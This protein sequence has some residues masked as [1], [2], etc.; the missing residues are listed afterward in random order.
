MKENAVLTKNLTNCPVQ[1]CDDTSGQI[2]LFP[3]VNSESLMP[4]ES[5]AN[6]LQETTELV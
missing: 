4:H 1:S 2:T 3:S 6:I 5:I